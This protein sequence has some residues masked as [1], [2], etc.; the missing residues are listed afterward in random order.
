MKNGLAI[1][2]YPHR[3]V[4][5]NV[6]FFAEQGFDSVSILGYHMDA[7]C[8]DRAQARQLAELLQKTGVALTVHHK[9]PLDHSDESVEAFYATVDRFAE[10]QKQCGCMEV[11]SF[12]VHEEVRDNVAPYVEYVLS[13]VPHA[14]IALED[15]GLTAAEREQI[16]HLKA[17]PRFGY[18]ID[19]GHMY[20]RIRGKNSGGL[21][22]FTNF[23]EECEAKDQPTRED[24]LHAFSSKEFPVF[25]IHLHNNDGINDMHYFFDD[26]TLDIQMMAD[27]LKEIAFDGILTIESAPGCQFACAYPESDRRILETFAMWKRCIGQ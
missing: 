26:G 3:T 22:L 15:F 4:L 2:H 27:V 17:E 18:L 23:S 10:W 8:M 19:I 5:E 6:A 20:I 13:A 25:E 14:K 9:L 16:E 7:V 24:F 21:T 12:D 11:L 1:W